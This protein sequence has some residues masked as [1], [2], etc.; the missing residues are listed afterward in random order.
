MPLGA[1][2]RS[3][4]TAA[5]MTQEELAEKAEV[6]A[7]TV[8]DV[9]RG[10]RT[11][12][13]RD[14]AGRLADAL[15]LDG[16]RRADFETA[17]KGGGAPS[18]S[19]GALPVPPGPV[20]GREREIAAVLEGFRRPDVRLLTLTGPG[21]IGKTRV[22]LEAASRASFPDGVFFA[23]LGTIIEP[24]AVLPLV[25]RALGVPAANDP[26]PAVI[27]HH[28]GN[29]RS[30]VVLDTFEHVM[31]AAPAIAEVLAA[32]R[33]VTMLATSREALRIR[34]EHEIPVPTL[35]IPEVASPATVAAT[36]ATALFVERAAAVQPDLV[37]DDEAAELITDI[38]RRVNGLP[39]AI[40][41]A[42]A[43]TK[44]LPL[45]ELRSQLASRLDVL[46]GGARDLPLRQRTMRGTVAWSY[47]LLDPKEQAV[48][49]DLCVFSGG[50][51]LD[52]ASAVLGT[53]ALPG[54]SALLDKSLV[55]RSDERY[56]MLD[57][58]REFGEERG[59]SVEARSRHL[60]FFTSL[61]ETAEPEIGA[62]GQ[63]EWIPRLEREHDNVRAALRRAL[64]DHDGDAAARLGGA[65]WRFWLL[66]GRLVE[67]RAWLRACLGA[68]H[69]P[70]WRTKS[71][72]G[73]AWLAY[74]Q[75]DYDEAERHGEELIVLAGD[76][77]V[78]SRNGST[79]RG[80]V[81]M[82]HGRFDEAIDSLQR[83]VELVREDDPSWL[84]G[85]SLL[86]LGIATAHARDPRAPAILDD[87]RA[88][89]EALGDEHFLA[90]T[91]VY[92]GYAALLNGE[93]DTAASFLK[94]SLVD[95]WELDDL[96]GVA[97]AL[98]GIAG[99]TAVRSPDDASA[100]LAGAA[101]SVREAISARPFAADKAVV[102]ERLDATRVSIGETRFRSALARGRTMTP[103]QAAD[104][105]IT[106]L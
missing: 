77:R 61:A 30:L 17:A 5:G 48:F 39:L 72:W 101:E 20:I 95:F 105:A 35:A 25:A 51:T 14:T 80:M 26:T 83:C 54:L 55:T 43:R 87:A 71:L 100:V 13:Y 70:R 58:V 93:L 1:L 32:C 78:A 89:Y 96:W 63:R 47:E 65:T 76:D 53:D 46:V 91:A 81:A 15:G 102:D 64:D 38:C 34:G 90:R 68:A 49:R 19:P 79:I 36:P 27:A 75:A 98:E 94:Q 103:E 41:L 28:L 45:S 12:I 8:S 74:H 7:R 40:E 4:R 82:A 23:Q 99:L 33:T 92:S 85:T 37:I 31:G 16:S 3:L 11:K 73:A 66:S 69:D 42:A 60:A 97:E 57:V 67:G 21:G 59:V 9:E 84:L 10:L 56:R 22:A 52:A 106:L 104:L 29:A 50:W 62:A 6:S 44:H 88:V 2:L 18:R 86:N 24:A